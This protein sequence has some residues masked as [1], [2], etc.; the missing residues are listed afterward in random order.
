MFITY[1]FM[2]HATTTCHYPQG[3]QGSRGVVGVRGLPGP[4]GVKGPAGADGDEGDSGDAVSIFIC[5]Y[6]CNAYMLTYM[7]DLGY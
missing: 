4:K 7:Q 6:A 3:P 1:M 5:V 2:Q